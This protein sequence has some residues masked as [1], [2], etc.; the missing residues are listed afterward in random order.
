MTLTKIDS[1][2]SD[3]NTLISLNKVQLEIMKFIYTDFLDSNIDLRKVYEI[4]FSV[5]KI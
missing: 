4:D 5:K 3:I 1:K 2:M